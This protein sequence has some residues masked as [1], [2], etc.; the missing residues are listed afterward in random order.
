MEVCL[1]RLLLEPVVLICALLAFLSTYFGLKP[2]RYFWFI[3]PKKGYRGFVYLPA[4]FAL[5]FR[6]I[7]DLT[8][9]IYGSE[10]SVAYSV[11]LGG[12]LFGFVFALIV[13]LIFKSSYDKLKLG[14][15]DRH[16]GFV[17]TF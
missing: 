9:Y 4:F 14:L 10:E 16:F 1:Y 2:I 6:F 12:L 13:K 15:K 3:F 7:S 8:G 17:E 5:V 11:H